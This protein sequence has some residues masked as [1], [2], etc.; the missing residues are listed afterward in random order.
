MMGDTEALGI[1]EKRRAQA[2]VIKPIY[3]VLVE[4]FGKEEAQS[5]IGTAIELAAVE[6]GKAYAEKE[7]VPP[8]LATFAALQPAWLRSDALKIVP[9]RQTE[10]EFEYNV[11]R[12]KYAEMYIEM[13]LEE[14]GHLLSCNRD[15][16]FSEGY[17]P[18]IKLKRTQ[19]IMQ[20]ASY[21]D[22]RYHIE[23]IPNSDD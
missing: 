3:Q 10:T 14:I 21:C 20:G 16:T 9:L 6:E 8:N 1:L 2:E 13:G 5:I 4:R 19:T 7:L 17:N 23:P 11:T 15:A 18:R 22:F 12:C